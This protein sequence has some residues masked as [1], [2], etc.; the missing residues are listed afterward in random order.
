MAKTRASGMDLW[1]KYRVVILSLLLIITLGACA[2]L[3]WQLKAV[4]GG[5]QARAEAE[6]AQLIK[7]V[8][9]NIELPKDE[10]PTVAT[11]SDPEALRSQPF[12]AKAKIGD[13]VL[14]YPNAK[15]AI[16]YDP[17]ADIVIEVAPINIGEE[18]VDVSEGTVETSVTP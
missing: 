10:M 3:A 8:G 16:L 12:F 13:R 18:Q 17:V 4:Q 11:V 14:L 7:D 15:K 6:I 1:K 5:D 9:D 2:Y